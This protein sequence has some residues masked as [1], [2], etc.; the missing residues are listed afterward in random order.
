MTISDYIAELER[1]LRRLR[2]PRARLLRETAD[3][4]HDLCAE[5]TAAGVAQ[6]KA[7]ERAVTQFGAA[8][9]IAARFAEATASTTA[10]RA[11]AVTA[12]AFAA[13]MGVFIAFATSASPQ[14]RD[15]PQGAASFLALQLAAVALGLAAVRSLRWRSAPAAPTSELTAI[16]RSLSV[17]GVALIGASTVEAAVA[18]SR[19]AGVIAWSNGRWLTLA[20]AGALVV[21]LLSTGAAIRAVAQAQAVA[22]LP[23]HHVRS[24]A[25]TLLAADAEALLAGVRLP[26]A[27]RAVREALAHPWR[28]TL[29]VAAL[30]F[31]VVT[32]AGAITS[33]RA[34]LGGSAALATVEALMI[35]LSFIACGRILG[36]RDEPRR[37]AR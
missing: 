7:E 19:P 6:D 31:V 13:Y 24:A 33:R 12:T 1:E 26:Q 17:A 15:F 25:P 36:L 4:L 37:Q 14:L 23:S 22:S 8:A 28:A 27:S 18:A 32:A 10:H 30:S 20:L 16:A 3:H 29:V 34:G 21:V 5:L 11:V 9:T 2:A 35:V